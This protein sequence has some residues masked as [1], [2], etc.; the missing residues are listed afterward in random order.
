MINQKNKKEIDQKIKAIKTD[1]IVG[2]ELLELF[3][4]L[5]DDAVALGATDIHIEPGKRLP[6]YDFE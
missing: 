6:R 4:Q 3:E 2:N 1:G 5:L